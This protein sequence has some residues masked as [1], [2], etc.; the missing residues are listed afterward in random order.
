MLKKLLASGSIMILAL[1]L[2]STSVFAA[3]NEAPTKDQQEA[4]K[5]I[6]K[7]NNE[8][9]QKIEKAVEKADSLQKKYLNDIK[10]IEPSKLAE[11]TEKYNEQLNEIITKLYDETLEIS[12]EAIQKAAELGVKAECTWVLVKLADQSVWIDPLVVGL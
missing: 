8:I 3:T 2:V 12:N 9:N 4:L 7:A 11:R 6:E 5:I 10:D 1:F